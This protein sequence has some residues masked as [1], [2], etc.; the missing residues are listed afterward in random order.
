MR[1]MKNYNEVIDRMENVN[2]S[3]KKQF[4]LVMA[5]E[6]DARKEFEEQKKK[7]EDKILDIE[8]TCSQLKEENN[9]YRF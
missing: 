7:L 1:N 5:S 8:N 6:Q 2:E 4:E 9:I 3:L